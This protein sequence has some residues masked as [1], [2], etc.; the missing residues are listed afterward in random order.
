M[1][2]RT[3][4]WKAFGLAVARSRPGTL[5]L[6]R[7]QPGVQVTGSSWL[8]EDPTVSP[9]MVHDRDPS[10]SWIADPR[11]PEPPLTVEL[12]ERRRLRRIEVTPPADI[13]EVPTRAVIAGRR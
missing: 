13:A 2:P 5:E 8:A 1:V 11:D 12:P 9:R 4:I 10:T 7:P 3:G 6:L